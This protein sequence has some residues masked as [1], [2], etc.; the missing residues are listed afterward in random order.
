M[1][2]ASDKEKISASSTVIRYKK[3]KVMFVKDKE[4]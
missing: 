2:K 4:K 3:S 1:A